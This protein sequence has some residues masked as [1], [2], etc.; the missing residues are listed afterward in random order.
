MGHS[1]QELILY[2]GLK[3]DIVVQYKITTTAMDV[4][5]PILTTMDGKK[6][7]TIFS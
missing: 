5:I 2:F 7:M 6:N 3:V 4:K 1:G